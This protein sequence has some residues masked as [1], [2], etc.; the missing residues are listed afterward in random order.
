MENINN[1]KFPL[2]LNTFRKWIRKEKYKKYEINIHPV[3]NEFIFSINGKP[4]GM[5]K[6][7]NGRLLATYKLYRRKE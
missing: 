4:F 7:Y 1:L 5:V 3:Y 6:Y 2:S